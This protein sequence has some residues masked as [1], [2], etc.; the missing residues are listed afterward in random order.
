M[1]SFIQEQMGT[2]TVNYSKWL[3]NLLLIA[4]ESLIMAQNLAALA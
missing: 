4:S 2:T 1:L 3:E